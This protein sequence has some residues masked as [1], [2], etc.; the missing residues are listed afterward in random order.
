MIRSAYIVQTQ[1]ISA[2]DRPFHD[3]RVFRSVFRPMFA[4][5]SCF[6]DMRSSIISDLV[7]VDEF[8]SSPFV[9]NLGSICFN[10]RSAV[11][12]SENGRYCMGGF[13]AEQEKNGNPNIWQ[14]MLH[15]ES[16]SPNEFF[17]YDPKLE[18][19]RM[20]HLYFE[21][22]Q[23]LFLKATFNDQTQAD[24]NA[25]V[26]FYLSGYIVIHLAISIKPQLQ[27]PQRK[28][29]GLIQKAVEN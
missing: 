21:L 11:F 17:G 7:D 28:Q 2:G 9:R 20:N 4:S 12:A 23:P 6:T 26:H 8:P 14:E 29:K 1:V 19:Q 22:L 18:D 10:A 3:D 5:K 27:T 15:E 24:G 13:L 25:F 16:L